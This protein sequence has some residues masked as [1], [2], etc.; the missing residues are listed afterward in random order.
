M[1]GPRRQVSVTGVRMRGPRRQVF[2][3]GVQMAR[4]H[5]V[6]DLGKTLFKVDFAPKIIQNRPTPHPPYVFLT[7]FCLPNFT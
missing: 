4:N 5:P 2:V 7:A 3:A 6:S 1:W